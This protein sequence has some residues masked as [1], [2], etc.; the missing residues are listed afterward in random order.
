MDEEKKGTEERSVEECFA[1]LDKTVAKLES[2]EVTLDESF[3]LYQEGML[4]L[5][6]V[7][8]KLDSYEKKMQILTDDGTLEDFG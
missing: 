6:Q 3:R 4:L 8:E 5:K 1:E 2:G 7:S